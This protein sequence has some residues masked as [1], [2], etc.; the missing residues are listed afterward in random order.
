MV[1][2]VVVVVVAATAQTFWKFKRWLANRLRH[3]PSL[4][5]VP[6][7]LFRN[8]YGF[9]PLLSHVP[10]LVLKTSEQP[11][12]NSWTQSLLKTRA[13]WAGG[14]V[15]TSRGLS[16]L[17]DE[18]ADRWRCYQCTHKTILEFGRSPSSMLAACNQVAVSQRPVSCRGQV[19]TPSMLRRMGNC[20]LQARTKVASTPRAR[21][22]RATQAICVLSCNAGHL[23]Q[24]QWSEVK[25]WL[26]TEAAQTCDISGRPLRNSMLQAGIAFRRRH[27]MTR[28]RKEQEKTRGRSPLLNDCGGTA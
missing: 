6:R 15:S 24:Q 2:V 16:L 21:A 3:Q 1:V 28:C 12:P 25:S 22:G 8:H 17:C 10:P 26:M 11:G 9:C 14:R 7:L 20:P 19:L 13:Y 27:Q 4:L 23:G 18:I 5:E